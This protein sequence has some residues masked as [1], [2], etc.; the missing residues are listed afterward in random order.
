MGDQGAVDDRMD[1]PPEPDQLRAA[2]A[3][4]RRRQSPEELPGAGVVEQDPAFEVADHHALLELGHQRAELVALVRDLG[5]R[6]GDAP[7]HVGRERPA[8]GGQR[9][10]RG[11]QVP[12]RRRPSGAMSG[13][14]P[15]PASARVA[16]ASRAG[17]ATQ[18]T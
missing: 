4:R 18:T 10:D 16:S 7:G 14:E 3:P 11:D 15:A 13:T 12:R 8:R 5:A 6:L 17:V 2:R 9:V 1:R